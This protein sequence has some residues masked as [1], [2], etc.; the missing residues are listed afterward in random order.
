ME[1]LKKKLHNLMVFIIGTTAA[2]K[3]KLSLTIGEQFNGE[4][5]SCDS[6]Q[7]YK[8]VDIMTAKA[9]Q[10]EQ[11]R[12]KHH[13]IDTLDLHEKNFNRNEYYFKSSKIA[14]DLKSQNKVPVIVG[15]THYYIETLMFDQKIVQTTDVNPNF[16]QEAENLNKYTSQ[17]L[18]DKLLQLDP[19]L[20]KKTHPN[21]TKRVKQYLN[22]ILQSDEQKPYSEKMENYEK[23]PLRENNCLVF[24]PRCSDRQTLR[25]QQLKRIREMVAEGGLQEALEIIEELIGNK[26]KIN[27]NTNIDQP[28]ENEVDLMQQGVLQSIG[29]K[30]FMPLY[31]Y[32]KKNYNNDLSVFK[33]DKLTELQEKDEKIKELIE[34]CIQQLALDTIHMSKKQIQWIKHRIIT[35]CDME[36]MK[37]RLFVFDFDQYT[38]ENFNEKVVKPAVQITQKYIELLQVN[39]V[40]TALNNLSQEVDVQ[41]YQVKQ[42]ELDEIQ[43][44]HFKKNVTEWQNYHC[45]VCDTDINGQHEY[46]I[47][48]ASK[49]HKKAEQHLEKIKKL[50]PNSEHYK[51]IMRKKEQKQ[52]EKLTKQQQQQ[53]QNIDQENQ[54]KANDQTQ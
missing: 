47:H 10:Q 9:T 48:M 11:A 27:E 53:Q 19:Q 21:N 45:D 52:K 43:K 25:E 46:E 3:T 31:K 5:I 23:V 8:K 30:E 44:H 49:K 20:A 24:W 38:S 29:Y 26:I 35:N 40:E 18:Y 39:D 16:T 51:A 33:Q 54:T 22:I 12:C 41:Q 28:L 6:M 34:N 37:K 32:L 13:L 14:E 7:I 36:T 2:G 1:P 4:I 15:G 50:D 42:S 17:Q